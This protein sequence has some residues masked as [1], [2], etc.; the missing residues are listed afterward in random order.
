MQHAVSPGDLPPEDV[1]DQTRISFIQRAR[2]VHAGRP[3]DVFLMDLGLAGVFVERSNPL[4]E[5]ESVEVVFPLPG[6]E[7]PVTAAGRVAW[8]HA[9]AAPLT[10]KSLPSGVGIEF[11]GL[12]EGNRARIREYLREHFRRSPRARQFAR[13]WPSAASQGEDDP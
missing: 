7:I 11:L 4:P 13:P 2:L 8:W 3:E 1:L 5:G 10:S 12:S 6:N 9:P